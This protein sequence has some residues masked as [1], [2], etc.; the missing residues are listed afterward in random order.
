MLPYQSAVEVGKLDGTKIGEASG[1]VASTKHPGILWTHNDR[2]S[3]QP[4]IK[5]RNKIYALDATSG[6][7]VADFVLDGA[8]N[9]DW[10]DIATHDGFIYVGDVGDNYK[11]RRSITIYRVPEPDV[12]VGG[13]TRGQKRISDW[14]RLNLKFPGGDAH[15]VEAFVLD[16]ISER[17]YL[18]TKQGNRMYT[19]PRVW[20]LGND[21][22][23]L[24][25][26]GFIREVPGD[27]IVGADISPDGTELL[28]K[29]YDEI[30]YYCRDV[31]VS[32]EETLSRHYAVVLDYDPEPKGESIA[33]SEDGLYTLSEA[34][35]EATVPLYF[36][37]KSTC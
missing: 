34:K 23:T 5:G 25:R 13:T 1:L 3:R 17:F 29:Y 22:M 10:E 26:A 6:D 27:V 36:Y 8:S 35:M 19:T 33:W 24:R 16:P 9:V 15:N 30:R 7:I 4:N 37:P 32:L 28:V 14:D 11:T 21:N 2:L 12:L 20:G 31:N 18:L